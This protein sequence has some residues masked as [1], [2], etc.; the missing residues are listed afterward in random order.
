[1]NLTTIKRNS[2]KLFDGIFCI[3]GMDLDYNRSN[4]V[5]PVKRFLVILTVFIAGCSHR[6]APT[7]QEASKPSWLKTTPFEDGYYTGIGHSNKA[8]NN[9]YIQEAKKSAFDDLVSEIKVNVSSTSVLSSMEVDKKLQEQYEQ[10]VKTTATDDIEE[11][12]LVDAWEDANNYWVYY[13][14]SIARYRQIKEEQKNNAVTLATDYLNKARVSERTG[15]YLQATGFYFQA[16]RSLEKYLGEAIRVQIEGQDVLLTNEIYASIQRMLE[17]INLRI[18]PS[19]I[20]LNRRV[21][22]TSPSVIASVN[23]TDGRPAQNFP[24]KAFFEKGEGDIFPQYK[25]DDKGKARILLNRIGSKE[26]EQRVVV[27]VDIDALSGNSNSLIYALIS[28]T[29]NV[30]RAQV[31][32]KVQRP[33]VYVTSDEKSLGG[34]KSY[35]QISNKLKNLLANNGFEFTD[36]KTSADLWF[37]VTADSEKGSISG[38]IYITY[39]TSIIKVMAMKEGKEIYATTLDRVKG[40]GLDYDKSS[41]DAYNKALETLEKE[42]M[43]EIIATVLE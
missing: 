24:L 32:L 40:Y 38:S 31:L 3:F 17:K 2:P 11:F 25:V 23:Y 27:Q 21:N 6:I 22:Q 29:F 12:E 28:K 30:P 41:V 39:L 4:P 5:F 18:D 36:D 9:N 20:L 10:I 43:H 37:D 7:D 19:E 26:L 14:L 42:R 35:T 33:V 1:M 13:R 15:D 8:G 34:S 16:L